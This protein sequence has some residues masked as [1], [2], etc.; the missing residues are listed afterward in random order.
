MVASLRPLKREEDQMKH[1]LVVLKVNY[2]MDIWFYFLV[3]G[4]IILLT[5]TQKYTRMYSVSDA[6][7]T[8]LL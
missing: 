8:Y 4:P 2:T 3:L 1:I 5:I 7:M 6:F